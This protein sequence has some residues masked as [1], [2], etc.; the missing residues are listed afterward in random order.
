MNV[1]SP[2]AGLTVHVPS[3]ATATGA[4]VGVPV[5]GS[6][7]VMFTSDGAGVVPSPSTSLLSTD[8]VVGVPVAPAVSLLSFATIG[9]AG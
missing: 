9:S 8:E 1:I 4:C 6:I 3:P 5:A 7:M 2:V